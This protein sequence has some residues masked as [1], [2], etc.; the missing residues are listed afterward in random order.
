MTRLVSFPVSFGLYPT[1][2]DRD[3]LTANAHD[4]E[5]GD[6]TTISRQGQISVTCRATAER[7]RIVLYAGL[8]RFNPTRL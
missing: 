3:G 6:Q 5:Q 4:I 7:P 2:R 1:N 8:Q